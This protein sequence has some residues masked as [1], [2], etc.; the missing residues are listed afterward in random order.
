M[1]GILKI[2]LICLGCFLIYVVLGAILP[3]AV[4]KNQTGNLTH[5]ISEFYEPSNLKERAALVEE[6]EDALITRLSMIEEAKHEIILST[7][8]IRTGKS[9]CGWNVWFDSYDRSDNF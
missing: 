7:F 3:F 6:N 4:T 1:K 5:E 2:I 9:V 8:D